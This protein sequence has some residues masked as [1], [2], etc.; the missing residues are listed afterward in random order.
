MADGSQLF[1]GIKK[2]R[3]PLQKIFEAGTH[4]TIPWN[5]LTT[6]STV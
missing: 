3:S 4:N 1:A 5:E 2:Y 6:F